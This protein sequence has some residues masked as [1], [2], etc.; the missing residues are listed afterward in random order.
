MSAASCVITI[1]AQKSEKAV[2]TLYDLSLAIRVDNAAV[3]YAAYILKMLWPSRL[4][5][6]YV[7][8]GDAL[9]AWKIAGAVVLL[10]CISALVVVY[11]R[12]FR[13][14]VTGWLW[15]LVTLVPVIGLVQVGAQVMADRYTYVP[16]IGLFIMIAWGIP[17]L[18]GRS[19]VAPCC[20]PIAARSLPLLAGAIIAALAVR[21]WVQTGYWKDDVSLFEQAIRVGGDCSL[22]RTTL[23]LSL[24]DRGELDKAIANYRIALELNPD[25]AITHNGLGFALSTKGDMYGALC[26]YRKSVDLDPKSVRAHYNLALALYYE[27]QLEESVKEFR[28][29]IDINRELAEAHTGLA[30]V[31]EKMGKLDESKREYRIAAGLEGGAAHGHFARGVA[32]VKQGKLDEAIKEYRLAIRAKPD[33]IEAFTNLGV[34]LK[35]RGRIDEAIEEYRKAL[36]INPR[37]PRIHNNYAVAL[38][39]K[40]EYAQAWEEVRLSRKFGGK[41]NPRFLR[42]LSSMMPEPKK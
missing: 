31:L 28:R 11:G 3:A 2:S 34:A 40:G 13:Y 20:R 7:H 32:L 17:D 15:Y 38:A 36:S 16:L 6:Y 23:G 35:N 5:I 8:P 37:I 42:D 18:F 10:V 24:V 30:L 41:P 1:I 25:D 33:F 9:P 14:L 26:E 4:A 39:I 19:D 22:V 27:K 12:R 21:T 29:V